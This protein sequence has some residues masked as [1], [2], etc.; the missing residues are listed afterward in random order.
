M[1]IDIKVHLCTN[2]Q[3]VK[4]TTLLGPLS[5]APTRQ[6]VPPPNKNTN[7]EK[8][9]CGSSI[10]LPTKKLAENGV[11]RMALV[12]PRAAERASPLLPPMNNFPFLCVPVISI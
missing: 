9:E 7:D 2:I 3:N 1:A 8:M 11:H 5:L 4:K 10:S 6:I 12:P